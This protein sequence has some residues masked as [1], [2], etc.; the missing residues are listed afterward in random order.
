MNNLEEN[1]LN[2][3]NNMSAEEINR[4]ASE[5][6]STLSPEQINELKS[7]AEIFSSNKKTQKVINNLQKKGI[8]RKKMLK[9]MKETKKS[10]PKEDID[11]NDLL[12]VILINESRKIKNLKINKNNFESN[13]KK[14]LKCKLLDELTC[15]QISKGPLSNKDICVFLDS[16]KNCEKIGNKRSGRITS[17]NNYG[18]ALFVCKN[19]D[20]SL[21]DFLEAEK[22][23]LS[24]K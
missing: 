23:L 17:V 21:E 19:D 11:K 6:L 24:L 4:L 8:T 16:E 13:I 1:A 20:I 2:S 14:I 22:E 12:E 3:I 7:R 5:H 10:A 15:F 9:Q 18:P